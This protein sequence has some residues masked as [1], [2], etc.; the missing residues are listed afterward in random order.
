MVKPKKLIGKSDYILDE[1][2]I[3]SNLK[4]DEERR[5][6]EMSNRTSYGSAFRRF[7]VENQ[8]STRSTALDIFYSVPGIEV[9]RDSIYI[10]NAPNTI[11]LILYDEIITNT[12]TEQQWERADNTLDFLNIFIAL[13]YDFQHNNPLIYHIADGKKIKKYG[14]KQII[15]DKIINPIPIFDF[16][17]FSVRN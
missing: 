14:F 4:T 11:P 1:V 16:M 8:I 17:V 7:D 9:Y 5:S 10:R 15:N 13:S 3:S 12:I 6:K 2:V